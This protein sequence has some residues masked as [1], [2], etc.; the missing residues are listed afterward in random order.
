MALQVTNLKRK[1]M[2]EGNELSDPNPDM[3]PEDVLS[4]YANTYPEMTS[5]SVQGPEMKD[6]H[7]LY[8][9]SGK[10]GTKG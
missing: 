2:F 8:T 5:G 10:V 9:L 1:F 4:F 7:V 3:A 6:D